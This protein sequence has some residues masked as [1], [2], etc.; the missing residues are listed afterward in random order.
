[1]TARVIRYG[2][3]TTYKPP[4]MNVPANAIFCEVVAC[5]RQMYGTGSKSSARSVTMLGTELARKKYFVLRHFAGIS[6]FQNPEIG[7][8]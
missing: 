2:N 4:S 8:H 7:V 1:M 3:L 6:L 5:K